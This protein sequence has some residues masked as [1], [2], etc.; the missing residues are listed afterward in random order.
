MTDH[1]TDAKADL[2]LEQQKGYLEA[3]TDI[4]EFL[5]DP[6]NHHL[7]YV[8]EDAKFFRYLPQTKQWKFIGP[9]ALKSGHEAVRK[10]KNFEVLKR[11]LEQSG[12]VY[13]SKTYD[14]PNLGSVRGEEL[15]MMFNDHWLK[16]NRERSENTVFFDCLLRSVGN[17]SEENILHLKQVIGWKYLH[18]AEWSLPGLCLYGRGGSG[19]NLLFSSIM[20][21]IFGKYQ[22]LT[23]NF[24]KVEKYDGVLAGQMVVM[25]DEHP[26]KEDQGQLKAIVGNPTL[27]VEL[28]N[29]NTFKIVNMA[30]YIIAT[31]DSNGPIRIEN[32]GSERRWSMIH[33]N[34]DLKSVVARE[35][36]LS[37][38]E[39]QDAIKLADETVFKNP[40]EVARFLGMCIAEAEK[41]DSQP[42]ALHG[43][44]FRALQE[45][46]KDATDEILE[47]VFIDYK[48]FRFISLQTLYELYKTRNKQLN[49]ASSPMSVQKFNGRVREYMVSNKR[50]AHIGATETRF[51]VKSLH[52]NIKASV[53]F[54]KNVF[55]QFNNKQTEETMKFLT[56]SYMQQDESQRKLQE[57]AS[58]I[59][60]SEQ[61]DY[62]D[63]AE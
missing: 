18:P 4:N 8:Q 10:G 49:P 45:N 12:R 62:A 43:A 40:D 3:L 52:K 36:N 38:E 59:I 27:S 39:A 53:F 9:D 56:C 37:I 22:T 7:Y 32:N 24:K 35:M 21:T 54:N 23:T 14:D 34:Q 19:K 48:D 2:P 46:Q 28:K 26:N 58:N 29:I 47:E 6:L 51:I 50:A 60:S 42:S 55:E 33:S 20:S 41:L 1:T 61:V 15:N 5:G 44:D 31:N 13:T 17:D 30:L 16:P 63:I 11:V 25:F 57:I